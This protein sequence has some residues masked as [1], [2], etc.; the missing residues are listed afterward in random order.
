MDLLDKHVSQHYGK[1][2]TMDNVEFKIDR[3]YLEKY[4]ASMAPEKIEGKTWHY[5]AHVYG[6]QGYHAQLLMDDGGALR[7]FYH[8]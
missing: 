7:V 1:S 6:G 5:V 2:I 3:N 8:G 4:H